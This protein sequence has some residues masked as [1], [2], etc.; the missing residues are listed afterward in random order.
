LKFQ[1]GEGSAF[2]NR[3]GVNRAFVSYLCLTEETRRELKL[4][5][6]RFRFLYQTPRK[7][8]AIEALKRVID[9][10]DH[11]EVLKDLGSVM[12]N[13]DGTAN[14]IAHK[15][16]FGRGLPLGAIHLLCT[17]EQMPNANSRIGLGKDLDALGLRKVTIDWRLSAE[18]KHGMVTGHRMF[19]AELGRAGFGRFRSTVPDDDNS[20]P[21]DM[22]GDEHHMG[23]TRMHRQPKFG[24]VDENCRVHGVSNLYVAGSSVF[25]TGGAA[26]PTLTIVALAL[27]LADQ[28]KGRL[29]E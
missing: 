16:L 19:G 12:R 15:M 23:T 14:Y 22:F 17:S 6:L 27:R 4:P 5:N 7:L 29:D 8:E 2:Y 3:F 13:L 9:R 21:E 20:W 1:T 24:V 26:N 25:P 18:D 11:G 10:T 28:I